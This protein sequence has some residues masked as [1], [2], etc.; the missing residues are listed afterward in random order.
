VND[1]APP[2]KPAI[3]QARYVAILD[4]LQVERNPR[5]RRGRQGRNETY[6]NLFV[7][8]A[9]QALGAP[10]PLWLAEDSGGRRYLNAN[11]MQAW[12]LGAGA[13]LG[14]QPVSADE[15]QQAA[16][17]GRP[18]V[19]SWKN[20][21]PEH[22]GHIAMLRPGACPVGAERGPRIAQ[23]GRHNYQSTDA[24]VGFG[25]LERLGQV[26]YFAWQAEAV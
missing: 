2:P 8:D 14:W 11:A 4:R 23:A 6:C 25:S 16:N 18:A 17:E 1:P 7:A 26:L 21:R 13:A 15:A 22:P 20:P 12:L 24:V 10:I 3:R 9:S 5:Y 19:A